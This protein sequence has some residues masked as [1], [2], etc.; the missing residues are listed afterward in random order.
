MATSG[1]YA[2]NPAL[3]EIV[4]GAY[5]RCG[6]RRTEL[7]QQHMEDARF[8]SNMLMSNWAGNG[9]NLWQVD[10]GTINLI[11]GQA[12]YT[13]PTNT[14]FLLDVYITQGNNPAINRL[15]LPISRTDYASIANKTQQGFPTSYWFDRLINPN[16]YIW[17][18]AN[19]DGAYTLTYYRMRQA[20]D[21]ELS[22]GTNVEVPW[23]Q[24][25]AFLAGLASRLAVIYAPDKVQILE[26]LYQAS[27]QK[28]LQAGTENVPLKIS[29]QL[30]SYFR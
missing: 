2:F 30:R 12:A 18:L 25:D 5:A 1:T 26:P 11:Q 3:G 14:V 27:W 22:N 4:I 15:I 19:Q 17:P 6:I 29:P 24:L 7:T 8:E 10:T 28:V 9:I 16:L 20:Q 23:Y 13:I 21:S